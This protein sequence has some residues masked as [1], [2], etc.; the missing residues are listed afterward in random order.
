MIIEQSELDSFL[1]ATHGHPHQSLGIHVVEGKSGPGVVVRAFIRDAK[2]CQVVA[3]ESVPETRRA[4]RK[5]AD[6]GFFEGV[7][8]GRT[9]IFRYRLRV[10]LN[11]G[12]VRQF[13]D[14]YSFLPS[15]SDQDVYLFNE[16][17][18]HRLYDKLGAH[19]R[20]IEGVS[21]VAFAVW[22]PNAE[23][24]SAVGEFNHWDGRYHPMRPLGNSGLW[25]LFIPGL[26]E[27]VKY[28]YELLGPDG[29][30][31]LKADPFATAFE[32]PPHNASI[33]MAVDGYQ[34]SDQAWMKKRAETD[35]R[36]RPISVYE[37]HVGSWKRVVEDGNRPL[38]YRELADQLTEYILDTGFTH[39]EFLPLAEHPFDGSWGYQVTGFFAP[40]HRFGDP[41]DLMYLIDTLHQRG[42]GVFMD[43]VPGH[44]P[45][46][47][48]A[49]AQFDGTHLYEHADPRQGFHSD[50]GTLVFNYDRHEVKGFLIASA[51]A[52]MERYHVDGLRVDAVASMLYLDYSR[53]DGGWVPN[54]YGG[55][56][57][58][59]AIE[60]LRKTNEL[61]HRY[62]PG[63]LMIAEE[64][65]A[66]PGVT[67]AIEEGGLGFDFKWN[68]GW[69]HDTLEYFQKD[70]VHRRWHHRNLT[71][72]MVYQ[73]HENFVQAF[74]HDEVVH[75]KGSMIQKMAAG[76]M[77]SKAQGLRAMYALMWAW[78][79]KKT[80]FMGGEFGQSSEWRYDGSLEWGLLEYQDHKGVQ[81]IIS[82]LNQLYVE[83]P[84]LYESDTDP[85]GFSWINYEDN[86]NSVI[87][88]LRNSRGGDEIFVVVGNF[89]PVERQDYRVGVPRRGFWKEAIN[90]DASDYGGHACGNLGGVQASSVPCDGQPFSMQVTLPRESTLIFRYSLEGR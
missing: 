34:W 76:D 69:M 11:N 84:G 42:I 58:I 23:R 44:F 52:W 70:P 50:W 15:L 26:E 7:L 73:Y 13:F 49:L 74:S 35:W 64:S 82:D 62:H 87:S 67:K 4:L 88:F 81:M 14:P 22:A 28:K 47:A 63:A 83:S 72:G 80:L 1:T 53:E 25:E 18:E 60:F 56:E 45:V 79:G 27:G 20:V 17:S 8:K 43:W 12:E 2:S 16:G 55:R 10:V 24:V 65:T 90:S 85:S 59:A 61:V 78:P 9:D 77:T 68:M 46:D 19:H 66:W 3:F 40:T 89:T 6:E 41:Y 38:G 33:V 51:L 48:F 21:G 36:N 86:E 31:R 37:V 71:F 75:G 29:L 30:L 5:I 54:R 32:S 57:N 39:V